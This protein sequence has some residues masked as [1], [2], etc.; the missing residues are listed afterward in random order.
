MSPIV[1]EPAHYT[2][3]GK[4]ISFPLLYYVDSLLMK[5]WLIR[6]S[7]IFLWQFCFTLDRC[8]VVILGRENFPFASNLFTLFFERSQATRP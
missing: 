8:C 3:D 6:W 2:S 4:Y 1:I 5:T 7:A